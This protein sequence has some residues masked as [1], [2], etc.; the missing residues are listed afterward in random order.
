MTAPIP[1]AFV[2]WAYE[3]RAEMVR[4]LASGEQVPHEKVFLSFTRHNPTVISYGS[5]GLNGSIKGV[6]WL[7]KEAFLQE[8][9]DAYLAHIGSGWSDAYSNAGLQLLVS[10]LYGEDCHERI[11]FGRLGSLELAKDHSWINFRENPQATL[12]FY[13]PPAVSYEVR[14]RVEIHEE[15]SIYHKLINAQH[16][17]YHQPHVERWPERPAYVFRIE[18]I[19]DNSASPKGFGRKI[20]PPTE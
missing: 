4:R 3:G 10:R 19:F 14:G 11:D 9:L 16:D 12:V 18:E 13:Q 17:T 6:G 5:A 15:G 7:P 2:K 1:E 8:T 20:H